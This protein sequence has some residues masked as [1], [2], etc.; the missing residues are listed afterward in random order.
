MKV[1]SRKGGTLA[2]SL[3][4]LQAQCKE[5]GVP[6]SLIRRHMN[7]AD[8]LQSLI[9]SFEKGKAHV[10]EVKKMARPVA[11]AKA[12]KRPRPKAIT[13]KGR[14]TTV[15]EEP[16]P[17]R[18]PATRKP[19]ARKAT[20]TVAKRPKRTAVKTTARKPVARKPVERK[21][22][23]KKSADAGRHEIGSINFNKT[24]GWNPR[25]GSITSDIFDALK[26]CKGDRDKAYTYLLK[27]YPISEWVPVKKPNGVR[28]TKA[29]QEA[30]LRYR[31]NRTLWD[32]AIQ[33]GQH[34]KSENRIEYG[35]GNGKAKAAPARR[36][37]KPKPKAA[38]ARRGR[39]KATD[40]K[41]ST[42]K[43]TRRGRRP[44][45]ARR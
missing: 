20:A 39:P 24:T 29:E 8:Q 2:G 13:L 16:K 42:T 9:E 4:Q 43:T 7:D 40:R 32:F 26:A 6:G 11:R 37:A 41:A 23:R 45:K 38:P 10:K 22:T 5:L 34:D 17:T 12:R 44:A 19:A 25:E 1:V 18:K 36:T 30:M 3:Q 21:V 14:K 31:I 27:K 15:E 33:T 35:S 28:R